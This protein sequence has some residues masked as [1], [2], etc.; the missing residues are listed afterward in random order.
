M[1][2]AREL[3]ITGRPRESLTGRPT[4]LELQ[5]HK[6]RVVA[7]R[8]EARIIN[9]ASMAAFA[10][11]PGLSVYCASKAA[12]VAM[13]KNLAREWSKYRIGVNAI[14]PGYIETEINSD[15]FASEG[16]QRQIQGFPRRRLMDASS[17]DATFMMLAGDGSRF[18]TGTAITIDDGQTL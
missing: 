8:E 5:S 12:V 14:C 11:L 18:M 2:L 4:L 3:Q 9:I 7:E 6:Q 1:A 10:T 13:T 15:W 16:G 17:L